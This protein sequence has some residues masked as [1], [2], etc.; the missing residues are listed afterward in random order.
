VGRVD[1]GCSGWSYAHWRDTVY[2][3]RPARCWLELYAA[4]FPTVEVNASFYRLPQRSTVAAWA[5][6]TP[7]D[8]QFSIK[9]SRYLTH[10]R[11]LGGVR[12][13]TLRLL[14]R[15]Q[16]LVESRRLS[17]LLWQLPPAFERDD[18]R[19][20]SALE[21]MPEGIRNAIE[22]R[23][24]SWFCAR[25]LRL[26]RE[27]GATLVVGDD[28]SRPFQLHRTTAELVYVRLHRGTRGRR[29]NYSPRELDEWASRIR[30]WS[31]RHDVLA[32]FNNDWETFAVRNALDLQHRLPVRT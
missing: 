14:D 21:A 24:P 32:Y 7:D 2:G 18:R 17:A 10:I 27:A 23:H 25:V 9:A 20:A 3:G 31:T 1:I 26:L 13:G 5:D 4:R 11:R 16:P 30:R 28:P 8:F 12:E 6:Q 29:G 22:F 19:L 15:L